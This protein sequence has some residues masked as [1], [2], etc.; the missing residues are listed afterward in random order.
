MSVLLQMIHHLVI[1]W[2]WSINF[3]LK[4]V[5]IV[6]FFIHALFVV[7]IVRYLRYLIPILNQMT[8]QWGTNKIKQLNY[9]NGYTEQIKYIWS[10]V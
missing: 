4:D 8:D 7:H 3:N 6:L 9:I 10:F 1:S 5:F 2:V